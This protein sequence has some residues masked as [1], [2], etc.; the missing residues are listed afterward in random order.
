M[1]SDFIRGCFGG[2][3]VKGAILGSIIIPFVWYLT[4]R[5]INFCFNKHPLRVLFGKLCSNEI[6]CYIYFSKL[7]DVN[8]QNTYL[9]NLADYFPPHTSN[10][11]SQ[12]RNTPYVWAEGDGQC[13]MDVINTLGS[14]GKVRNIEIKDPSKDWDLWNGNIICVGGS[15]KVY[16]ILETCKSNFCTFCTLSED[17]CRIRMPSGEEF[18]AINNDD[19]G[20]IQKLNNPHMEFD[21]WIILGV[22]VAGTLAAGAYLRKHCEEMGKIFGGREF[23]CLIKTKVNQGSDLGVLFKVW[24]KPYWYKKILHPILWFKKYKKCVT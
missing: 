2:D 17:K 12:K 22:G 19:Y 11:T 8:R 5:I 23:C 24:P 14:I 7:F 13:A 4:R 10:K 21:Y 15:E 6:P 9:Y 1:N 16:A 3:I 18:N 20:M